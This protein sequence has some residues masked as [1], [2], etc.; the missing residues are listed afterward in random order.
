MLVFVL[1]LVSSTITVLI[2]T[3]AFE[4]VRQDD[5]VGVNN[6]GD[7]LESVTL[8]VMFSLVGLEKRLG[9]ASQVLVSLW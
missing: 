9:P 7:A 4:A 3:A 5:M 6:E 8:K 1:P 2:E